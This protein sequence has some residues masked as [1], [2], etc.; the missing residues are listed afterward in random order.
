M[1]MNVVNNGLSCSEPVLVQ[2]NRDDV[3]AGG[4]HCDRHNFTS[5]SDRFCCVLLFRWQRDRESND[6]LRERPP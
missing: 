6:F 4:S 2:V 3:Q 5:T 1:Q